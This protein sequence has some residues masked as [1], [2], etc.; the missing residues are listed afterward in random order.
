MPAIESLFEGAQAARPNFIGSRARELEDLVSRTLPVLYKRAFRFLGNAPDAEDAVQDALLSACKHLGQFREHAQLST[1]LTAIVLNSAR[2]QLRRRR[3]RYVSLDQQQGED[4]LTYSEQ[5]ADSRPGPEECSSASQVHERLAS[6]MRQ[7]SPT[8]R[9][10]FQL[11]DLDGLTTR[12]AALVLGVPEGTVK[13]QLSRAR[14]KLAEIMREKSGSF[15]SLML[16]A[17]SR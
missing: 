8:L 15:G 5:L 11:R 2:M 10:T 1:W 3:V 17:D 16:R 13:A 4:G 7:L 6:G 14:A 9:R 12:E